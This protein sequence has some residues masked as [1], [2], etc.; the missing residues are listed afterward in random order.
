VRRDCPAVRSANQLQWRG[1]SPTR[2]RSCSCFCIRP[3]HRRRQRRWRGGGCIRCSLW[4]A[5]TIS[6]GRRWGSSTASGRPGSLAASPASSAARRTSS[7]PTAASTSATLS[8]SPPSAAT[9]APATG[10]SRRHIHIR[11]LLLSKSFLGANFVSWRIWK[12]LCKRSL[13]LGIISVTGNPF[14]FWELDFGRMTK[15]SC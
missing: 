5:A 9:P 6:T 4:S 8:R 14:F 7:P 11:A 2:W 15:M 13:F 1:R 10:N 3:G 12:F